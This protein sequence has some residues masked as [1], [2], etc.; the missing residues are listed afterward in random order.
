MR[1]QK[2]GHIFNISSIA[3]LVA[4]AGVGIYN[5]TKYALEGLSEALAAEVQPFGIKVK[6]IEPGSFRTD[7]LGSSLEVASPLPA[8]ANTAVEQARNYRH[9]SHNKK[10]GDPVKAAQMMIQL[11]ARKAHPCVCL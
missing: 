2:S 4:S 9:Q 5:S 6:I 3:G 10:N 7:F 1:S 8:Y 11:A